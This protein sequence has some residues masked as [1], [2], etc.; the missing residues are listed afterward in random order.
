MKPIIFLLI[1]VSLTVGQTGLRKDRQLLVDFRND[2]DSTP[3]KISQATQRTV[4]S[5]VF[6]RY[7]TDQNQCKAGFDAS[8]GADPL[9]AARKAGQIVPSITAMASGS[10]T[11][12]GQTQTAYV[13]EVSECNA[14]HAD[15]FGTKRVA[16]FSGQQLVADVDADFMREIVRKT[17]LNGDGID[18]LL[19][20]SGDMAQGTLIEMAT[21]VSFEN[22]RRSVLQEFGTVVEE[23]CASGFQGSNSKASV[24]YVPGFAPGMMPKIIQD[25]YVASCRNTK[26]WKFVSTGMMQE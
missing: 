10:F 20:T 7:L 17:D 21:L 19:M 4:L 11:A 1:V 13:F 6:R 24:L 8:N 3:F 23:S 22:G 16:I 5:K 25:N 12:A 2:H 26:R 18:E 9:A 15:N 14:S